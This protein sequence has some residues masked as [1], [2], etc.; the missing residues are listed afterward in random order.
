MA[1][2]VRIAAKAY[3]LYVATIYSFGSNTFMPSLIQSQLA[4]LE[5]PHSF[6]IVSLIL[7]TP[8][9][10]LRVL[11]ILFWSGQGLEGRNL[12]NRFFR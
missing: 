11:W 4:K 7:S 1:T 6:C 2:R 10:S 12:A 3:G 9:T 5:P 8:R